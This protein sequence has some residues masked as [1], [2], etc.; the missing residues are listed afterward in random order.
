MNIRKLAFGIILSV[1]FSMS[2]VSFSTAMSDLKSK[3]ISLEELVNNHAKW[4]EAFKK[5]NWQYNDLSSSDRYGISRPAMR[6]V[7]NHLADLK[8]ITNIDGSEE[9]ISDSQKLLASLENEK[10]SYEDANPI[11]KSGLINLDKAMTSMIG[12][13][14]K[15]FKNCNSVNG[16][17]TPINTQSIEHRN[18]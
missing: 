13:A 5:F 7:V 18:Q 10:W 16:D 17:P 15:K 12:R 14:Q 3:C 11:L 2:S 8:S 1:T 4:S 6:K 9:L